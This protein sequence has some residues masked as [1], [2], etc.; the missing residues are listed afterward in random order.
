[1]E[2][3][4]LITYVS[5]LSS[6]AELGNVSRSTTERKKMSTKTTF[7]RIALVT[8]AALGMG[9]L[10]SVA[11]ASAAI[12]ADSK[13][14]YT[15]S[16]TVTATNYGVVSRT[17]PTAAAGAAEILPSSSVEFT[18]VTD[19]ETLGGAAA[20]FQKWTIAGEAE[21]ATWSKDSDSGTV[22][23]SQDKKTLTL[24]GG[25]PV[26]LLNSVT[27]KN[28]AATSGTITVTHS[29]KV[30]ATALTSVVYTLSVIASSAAT[31]V[32]TYNAA[33]SN[34][35]LT[36]TSA[37]VGT[38]NEDQV[39]AGIAVNGQSVFINFDFKDAFGTAVA[40]GIVS[41]TV[42]GGLYVGFGGAG[43]AAAAVKTDGVSGYIQVSQ[44]TANVAGSGVVT[45]TYNG[46]AIG[47]K[48]VKIL[49]DLASITMTAKKIGKSSEATTANAGYVLKDAAGNEIKQTGYT[50][51]LDTTVPS[52]IVTAFANET[53]S[54][55]VNNATGETT[56]AAVVAGLGKFTC[57]AVAGK[58][59][60]LKVK[61]TNT[62]GTVIYSAPVDFNCAG[63][64]STYTAA[65]D[66]KSYATGE[67]ATLTITALDA[68][69]NAANNVD[70]LGSVLVSS[71]AFTNTADSYPVGGATTGA[72]TDGKLVLKY[73]VGQTAGTYQAVITVPNA[74]AASKVVTLPVAVTSA[75]AS[76]IAQLVKVIGT[77]LTTF[78]KQIAAL[79]K[80][81]G[82]R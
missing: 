55:V 30:S 74:A 2:K 45:V 62:A 43:S 68:A 16:T 41:A 47:T 33:K 15:L 14:R 80:A 17:N 75:G 26:T 65:F 53:S 48:S 1:V 71:G 25:I 44:G 52:T 42:T 12:A 3:D 36:P 35:Q 31:A 8:V 20:D 38:A 49:G 5:A 32:G 18:Q 22:T 58:A 54:V 7:K 79:I 61:A 57:S 69:G 24:T 23:I 19:G 29:A 4:L 82:K 27:L 60:G 50:L 56:S 9:V 76:E 10:T 63:G 13:L 81:L 40:N 59:A 73:V 51:A 64:V 67:V 11:P 46:A 21:W 72:L 78:T 37:A 6:Q 34:F 77:L 70:L 28:T 39:G 66:K